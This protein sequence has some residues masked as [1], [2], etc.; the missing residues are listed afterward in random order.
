MERVVAYSPDQSELLN[1]QEPRLHVRLDAPFT[2]FASADFTS[3]NLASRDFY[4]GRSFTLENFGV[5]E[6]SYSRDKLGGFNPNWAKE[7]AVTP[8]GSANLS[9]QFRLGA[10]PDAVLVPP[11]EM[12]VLLHGRRDR[13]PPDQLLEF[14]NF[15]RAVLGRWERRVDDPELNPLPMVIPRQFL[16]PEWREIRT[17]YLPEE[18]RILCDLR[19]TFLSTEPNNAQG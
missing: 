16:L 9:F 8:V 17:L 11:L 13:Y 5:G 4:I 3:H 18:P 2:P 12:L 15:G 6:I 7:N 19:V 14:P 1:N 10:E